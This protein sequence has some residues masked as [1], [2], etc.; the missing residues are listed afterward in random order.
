MCNF[1]QITEKMFQDEPTSR[2]DLFRRDIATKF[3]KY[4]Q[5]VPADQPTTAFGQIYDHGEESAVS[6]KIEVNPVRNESLDLIWKKS[7]ILIN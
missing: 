1:Q 3:E 4:L 7:Q 2:S 5:N 6:R